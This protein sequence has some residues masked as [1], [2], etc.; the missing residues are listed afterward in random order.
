MES[1]GLIKT[2]R[3]SQLLVDFHRVVPFLEYI[4]KA[5]RVNAVTPLLA[6]VHPNT[7]EIVYIKSGTQVYK[8]DQREYEIHGG[9]LFVTYPDEIHSSGGH[10]EEKEDMYWM[11]L[12]IN[13][14]QTPIFG[15]P[16]ETEILRKK[17][18]SLPRIIKPRVSLDYHFERILGMA[19][20]YEAA[21]L[22]KLEVFVA[23]L[24]FTVLELGEKS[25]DDSHFSPNIAAA[26]SY[27]HNNIEQR[28]TIAKICRHIGSSRCYFQTRF[29]NEVGISPG[30]YVLREKIKYAQ[31]LL[32]DT[33]LSITDIAHDLFFSSSQHFATTFKN[34]MGMTPTEY[35]HTETK[36]ID[37]RIPYVY[38]PHSFNNIEFPIHTAFL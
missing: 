38:P 24:L 23:E 32:L 13:A 15:F 25:R 31:E 28:I 22:L 37:T 7:L 35:R 21:W 16:W 18:Q 12:N 3:G 29:L 17:L 30:N 5:H 8:V 33:S 4:G 9:E 1:Q 19:L 20:N 34:L 27:I 14:E 10:P 6:H 11:G 36:N 26:I 2:G